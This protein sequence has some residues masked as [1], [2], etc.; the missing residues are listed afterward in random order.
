M[1]RFGEKL[2][3]LRQRRNLTMR[4]LATALEIAPFSFI[5]KLEHGSQMPSPELIVK[6]ARFFDVS[7]DQLMLDEIDLE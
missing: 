1:Q 6:I 7:T 3:T 5:S 2:R 4:E